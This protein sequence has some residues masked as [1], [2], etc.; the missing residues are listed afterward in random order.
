MKS[1]IITYLPLKTE[2]EIAFWN[3]FVNIL[4]ERGYKVF[5]LGN[6]FLHNSNVENIYVPRHLD[7]VYM[8]L[9]KFY[10]IQQITTL[11]FEV[12]ESFYR[13]LQYGYA[14]FDLGF[15]GAVC[16]K[17]L[18]HYLFCKYKIELVITWTQT[19]HIS[20]ITR[21]I[22]K[23]YRVPVYEAERAPFNEYIWI[24]KNGIFNQSDIYKRYDSSIIDKYYIENG[25]EIAKK[26]IN[27]VN[28][29]RKEKI[30]EYNLEC[31]SKEPLFLLLMDS[32][33]GSCWLPKEFPVSKIRYDNMEN[34]CAYINYL[35]ERIESLGGKLVVKPHPSCT[36]LHKHASEINA[37]VLDVNLN[38]ILKQ[39][40]YVICNHTKTSFAALA[41]EKKLLCTRNNIALVSGV[42]AYFDS[43]NDINT[44]NIY[45]YDDKEREKMYNFFGWLSC[46]YFYTIKKDGKHQSIELL[47]NK[48]I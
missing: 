39:A 34:P 17:N 40:D 26:V 4:S 1:V 45:E 29:F 8:E 24:E 5:H 47:I 43:I 25:R 16:I 3:N 19:T 41:L 9:Y 23:R 30:K 15:K 38:S 48:I 14:S 37:K 27:N 28:C 22:A 10:E 35:N 32:V 31:K 44:S 42:G 20:Y 12:Y 36:Y 18:I 46:E 21:K 13:E 6:R 11:D 33:Y 2:F 7:K